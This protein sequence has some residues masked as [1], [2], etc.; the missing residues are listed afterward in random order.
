MK[1][2]SRHK[3]AMRVLKRTS[4]TFYIPITLLKKTLKETVASAYLCMRA[5]DEIEDHEQLSNHEKSVL[6]EGIGHL[7]RNTFTTEEYLTLI[8]P[9]KQHLPE[10][11]V[12]LGDWI[13]YCP[14]GIVEDVKASTAT[15]ADGMAKWARQNWEIKT[16]EDLDDYTYYVAGLVGVMLSDIWK[17][18]DGTETDKDLAIGFG[19]GLQIVNILRNQDEDLERGVSFLPEDWNRDDLFEYAEYQLSLANQYIQSVDNRNIVTFCKIPY[20]LADKTLNVM[21]SGREKMTREEV[22]QVVDEVTNQSE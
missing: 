19:R 2:Q 1:N 20:K 10:V 18:Y 16:K 6:L 21:K 22:G 3:D 17:W 14:D 13:D 8:Q 7:L 15:M 4:R 11:T 5:I 9:Y 12:K